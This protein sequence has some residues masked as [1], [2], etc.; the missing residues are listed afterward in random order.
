MISLEGYARRVVTASN[1]FRWARVTPGIAS[2]PV[3][4]VIFVV[5]GIRPL[6][7]GRPARGIGDGVDD[8]NAG[9]G[10]LA[11]LNESHH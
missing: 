9:I 4:S 3:L 1:T 8:T 5:R 7:V 11:M 6:L 2:T 10:A